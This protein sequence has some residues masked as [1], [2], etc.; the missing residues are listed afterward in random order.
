MHAL[1]SWDHGSTSKGAWVIDADGLCHL[2]A[3]DHI[4]VY[5]ACEVKCMEIVHGARE[6]L[7]ALINV[8]E[9]HYDAHSWEKVKEIVHVMLDSVKGS[10]DNEEKACA[11]DAATKWRQWVQAAGLGGASQAHRWSRLPVQWRPH[12]VKVR[13]SGWSGSPWAIL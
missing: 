13:G 2:L 1:L 8:M 3:D 9:S 10:L 4:P 6:L 11:G 5:V 12:Q 7:E